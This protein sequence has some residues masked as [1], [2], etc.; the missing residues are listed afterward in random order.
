MSDRTWLPEGVSLDKPSPARMYD[1]FLGGYHNFEVDRT[2]ARKVLEGNP[3]APLVMRANRAFLRRAVAFLVQQGITQFLDIGSG[4]PTVGNSHE[5]A[6]RAAPDSRVVYVDSDPVAVRHSEAILRNN[7]RATIIQADARH[8][9]YILAHPETR[10]L[11]DFD[12]PIG[13]LIVSVMLF[14][15]DDS[16]AY[17]LVSALLEPLPSGSYLALT[18]GTYEGVPAEHVRR[19]EELYARTTN[20]VKLRSRPAIERF[21]E[22]LDLVEPGLVYVPL[23]RPEGPDELLLAEP[24]RS[25]NLAGVGRKP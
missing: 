4:I 9:D 19:I 25:V 21:F 24:E 10:R 15:P 14:V 11:L 3:D 7:S 8:P 20:P 1:Y 23:W 13:L 12:R 18:H 22:G 6:Q 17:R 2:A 5:V 16:E